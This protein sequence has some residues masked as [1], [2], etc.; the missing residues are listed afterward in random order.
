MSAL[1]KRETAQLSRYVPP[2]AVEV[3]SIGDAIKHGSRTAILPAPKASA[4]MFHS[5]KSPLE[6]PVW[7]AGNWDLL[8]RTCVAVVGTREVSPAGAARAR[9]LAKELAGHGVVVVSGLAYGVDTEALGS[10]ISH[11]GKTVAVIGTPIDKCTPLENAHLQETIYTEH[12]LISQF[13]PGSKVYPSNFPVRNRLMAALSDATVIVEATDDSGTLHQAAECARL[14]RWLFIARS[15]ADDPRVSWPK[16]FLRL[17]KCV[18]LDSVN[19]ILER[20]SVR[21]V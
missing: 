5:R 3:S 1:A 10:A 7:H 21:P 14:G 20:I 17:E 6:N 8:K 19:D 4:D 12:L 18:A 11:G 13:E 16:D 15:L 9:R 2:A